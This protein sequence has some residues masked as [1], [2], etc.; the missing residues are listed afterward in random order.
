M[1]NKE[2]DLTKSKFIYYS[3]CFSQNST[4]NLDIMRVVK[5]STYTR[6][7]LIY[8]KPQKLL[9]GN[10]A[11]QIDPRTYI[12]PFQKNS[13]LKLLRA[14]NIPFSPQVFKIAQGIRSHTFSLYF[15]PLC[16]VTQIFS[17]IENSNCRENYFN[18]YDIDL[19]K[20]KPFS[21]IQLN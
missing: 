11:I 17:L 9:F 13:K 7:D 21:A 4:K 18:I 14:E 8:Y 15:E 6:I 16:N 10:T 20:R 5:E 3:P 2:S 1:K 12:A 19:N